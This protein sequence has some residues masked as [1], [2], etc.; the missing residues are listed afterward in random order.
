MM[1]SSSRR[2]I[3]LLVFLALLIAFGPIAAYAIPTPPSQ[4]SPDFNGRIPRIRVRLLEAEPK[5]DVRAFD[6]RIYEKAREAPARRLAHVGNR[7]GAWVFHCNEGR[8]RATPVDGGVTLELREPVAISTPAGFL[9][10]KQRPYRE[11]VLLY[12]VGS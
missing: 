11:E 6:L 1:R 10:V 4:A 7:L 8:I 9:N 12:S 3:L 2:K 5:V